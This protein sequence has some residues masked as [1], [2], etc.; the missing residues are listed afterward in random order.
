[1]FGNPSSVGIVWESV[2]W[3]RVQSETAL[4]WGPNLYLVSTSTIWKLLW[5]IHFY[6]KIKQVSRCQRR[7][8]FSVKL[9]TLGCSSGHHPY[10][11]FA[12]YGCHG[13]NV[14]ETASTCPLLSHTIA[15]PPKLE[16]DISGVLSWK[17]VWTRNQKFTGPGSWDLNMIRTLAEAGILPTLDSLNLVIKE[18]SEQDLGIPGPGFLESDHP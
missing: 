6:T 4:C 11:T 3:R 17:L 15:E 14:E 16:S 9:P 10:P 7:K 18:S 2:S 1:M 8:G 12:G 13:A 5:Q